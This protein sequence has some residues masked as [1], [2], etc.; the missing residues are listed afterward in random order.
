MCIYMY[1]Y[2]R[3]LPSNIDICMKMYY[4]ISVFLF[5]VLREIGVETS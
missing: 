5:F 1:I 4:K 2:I 3:L